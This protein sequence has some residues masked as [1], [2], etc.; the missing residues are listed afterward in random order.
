MVPGLED[1]DFVA[2]RSFRA[3]MASD[4]ITTSV[5]SWWR[6]AGACQRGVCISA[7]VDDAESLRSMTTIL[8]H[9]LQLELHT[10]FKPCL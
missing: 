6:H 7:A 3:A 8:E 1:N 5:A 9:L 4:P 2:P 10:F